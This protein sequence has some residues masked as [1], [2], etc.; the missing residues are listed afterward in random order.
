MAEQYFCLTLDDYSAPSFTSFGKAYYG[1]LPQIRSFISSLEKDPKLC[2]SKAALIK[3]FHEY[4][5]GKLDATHPV[6]Y[7]N[8]PLLEP[9]RLMGTA[10]LRFDRYKWDHMNTWNWPYKMK[11]DMVE[12]QHY[13]IAANGYYTRC[14]AAL[15]ENL[16]YQGMDEWSSVGDMIWGYPHIIEASGNLVSNTLLVEEKRFSKRKELIADRDS[17]QENRDVD[18]M[19][20][21]NDIFGDG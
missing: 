11:C 20:F 2:K 4:E 6:A 16:S 13:W 8:V 1:T 7:Q 9:V 5:E 3:A 10:T 12:T 19:Q 18:F 21:C 17:F 15:F 14:V